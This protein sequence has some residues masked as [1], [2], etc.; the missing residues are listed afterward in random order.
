MCGARAR[1]RLL[2]HSRRKRLS[3]SS[4]ACT[5]C[6]VTWGAGAR[7]GDRST[8]CVRARACCSVLSLL[9]FKKFVSRRLERSYSTGGGGRETRGAVF[10]SAH[11]LRSHTR[12]ENSLSLFVV[13]AQSYRGWLTR[14]A[15]DTPLYTRRRDA[16]SLNYTQQR[17]AGVRGDLGL[18]W[19]L[20]LSQWP[21]GPKTSRAP[22]IGN[23]QWPARSCRPVR[24]LPSLPRRP[25]PPTRTC[26]RLAAPRGRRAPSP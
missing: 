25:A 18:F 1:L 7:G 24:A 20:R 2:K 14:N 22:S 10:F 21:A 19:W 17:C 13:C 23:G 26:A 3:S 5:K 15:R 12:A 16:A 4:C 9:I 6:A 8:L 11:M